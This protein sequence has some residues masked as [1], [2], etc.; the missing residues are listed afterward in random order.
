VRCL[1]S[2]CIKEK[3]KELAGFLTHEDIYAIPSSMLTARYNA[4]RAANGMRDTVTSKGFNM[5]ITSH[6]SSYG[7][8][9]AV[10]QFC[11]RRSQAPR[12]HPP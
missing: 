1:F 8:Y 11:D 4:W 3:T 12:G 2:F 7:A 10:Q 9:V 6:G 5:K